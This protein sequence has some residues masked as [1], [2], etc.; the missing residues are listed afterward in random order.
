MG[1][2]GGGVKKSLNWGG[3]VAVSGVVFCG[4]ADCTCDL[5]KSIEIV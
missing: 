1:G 3:D 4:K 2:G 5:V